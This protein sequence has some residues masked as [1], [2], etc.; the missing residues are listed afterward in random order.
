[1]DY[2]QFQLINVS[3]IWNR[4]VSPMP[5]LLVS[6]QVPEEMWRDTYDYVLE[7]QSKISKLLAASRRV[8]CWAYGTGFSLA[9]FTPSGLLFLSI[10]YLDMSEM[11]ELFFYLFLIMLIMVLPYLVTVLILRC[12]A[13]LCGARHLSQVQVLLEWKQYVEQQ[14]ALYRP[15]G[16]RLALLSPKQ[17]HNQGSKAPPTI[18]VG[19]LQFSPLNHVNQRVSETVSSRLAARTAATGMATTAFSASSLVDELQRLA[20]LKAQGALTL[21]E[22]A[23]AKAYILQQLPPVAVAASPNRQEAFPVAQVLT[24]NDDMQPMG[25]PLTTTATSLPLDPLSVES[26]SSD[27]R[28]GS[29]DSLSDDPQQ[30]PMRVQKDVETASLLSMQK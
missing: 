14:Q 3:G 7:Y 10:G 19:A 13:R 26:S 24:L 9:I 29:M 23:T 27:V 17:R 22:F 18:I 4:N 11:S 21:D 20:D 12:G 16:I 8:N 1:M 25:V 5:E 30:E 6:S 2:N 15:Y 28:P